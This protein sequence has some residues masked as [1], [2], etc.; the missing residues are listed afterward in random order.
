[1]SD[2]VMW[3]LVGAGALMLLGIL[4]ATVIERDFREA[5]GQVLFTLVLAPALLV[6]FL[7]RARA[8]RAIK[9]SPRALERFAQ[10]RGR[11]MKSAW[12]LTY[13]GRGIIL[14]R[15]SE[16]D[17]WLN[18]MPNRTARVSREAGR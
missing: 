9:L 8:P 10:Q 18:D 13:R 14:V 4:V 3:M 7:I 16:G 5:L 17:D 1:M 2:A 12:A 11:N 6:V 15:R